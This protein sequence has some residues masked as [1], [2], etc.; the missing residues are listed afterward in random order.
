MESLLELSI[1]Q[2]QRT[3]DLYNSYMCHNSSQG[4]QITP[5]NF[6]NNDQPSTFKTRMKSL[7]E[8]ITQ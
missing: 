6:Q 7:L 1:Q 3:T 4:F 8:P 2:N 5:Q